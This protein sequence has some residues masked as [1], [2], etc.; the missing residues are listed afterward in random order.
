MFCDCTA[1]KKINK[2]HERALLRIAYDDYC[3]S[4]EELLDKDGAV[5]IYQRN[6]RALA[7]EMYK[8]S[9]GLSPT[10][11][12]EMMNEID[13]PYNTRSSCQVE[14]DIDGNIT[15]FTKKSNYRCDKGI[16]QC[17]MRYLFDCKIIIIIR[18]VWVCITGGCLYTIH[19]QDQG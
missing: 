16:T 3:S 9:N 6:L 1:N 17:S 2:L 8:I 14:V 5:T 13:I 11:M 15:D 19:P 12:I 4:F 7:V 18:A 10:F